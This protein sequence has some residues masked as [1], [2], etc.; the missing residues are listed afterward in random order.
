MNDSILMLTCYNMFI[1][2]DFVPDVDFRYKY[3]GTVFYMLTGTLTVQLTLVI[4]NIIYMIV[5]MIRLRRL[6]NQYRKQMQKRKE[7]L[8][9]KMQE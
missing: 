2:T 8:I 4:C 6:R 3:S 1:F 5:G 9:R 7:E